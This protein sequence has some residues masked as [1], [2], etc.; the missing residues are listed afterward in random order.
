M[1]YLWELDLSF[2]KRKAILNECIDIC[3]VLPNDQSPL[4]T[5]KVA[6]RAY[7]RV[8]KDPCGKNRA[9]VDIAEATKNFPRALERAIQHYGY[10]DVWAKS[11]DYNPSYALHKANKLKPKSG[12]SSD[13][14]DVNIQLF[15]YG[16]KRLPKK[17][18][19]FI[20]ISNSFTEPF[21]AELM[22]GLD[23]LQFSAG[24]GGKQNAYVRCSS[25]EKDAVFTTAGG[26]HLYQCLPWTYIEEKIVA[27]AKFVISFQNAY[28]QKQFGNDF[29]ITWDVN[30]LHHVVGTI[31]QSVYGAHSDYSPLLC[32]LPEDFDDNNRQYVQ[33]NA[34]LPNREEMQVLTIH[35]SNNDQNG[36]TTENDI[37]TT[38]SYS[39]DGQP[40]GSVRS[41]TG[42]EI[43]PEKQILPCC[44][45][46]DQS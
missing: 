22:S 6:S 37:C 41:E 25:S 30:L 19:W 15:E 31:V 13:I 23:N 46:G 17:S 40:I 21:W 18:F 33:P 4:V 39:H 11:V 20:M 27:L 8:V 36:I 28:V 2:S 26:R 10:I 42:M 34:Y 14:P 1:I 3:N 9:I 29:R 43:Q 44:E 35:Y 38:I 16:G 12:T 5:K 24:L 45:P 7:N 32:S